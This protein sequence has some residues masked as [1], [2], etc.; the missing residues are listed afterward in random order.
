M[1]HKNT[2]G[3][4]MP[5]KTD[6]MDNLRFL[7]LLGDALTWVNASPSDTLLQMERLK[8][9]L[10]AIEQTGIEFAGELERETGNHCAIGDRRYSVLGIPINNMKQIGLFVSPIERGDALLPTPDLRHWRACG[11]NEFMQLQAHIIELLAIWILQLR[12]RCQDECSLTASL[13]PTQQ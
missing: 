8:E 3:F 7:M 11:D 10:E 13:W 4:T 9:G 6:K 12:A 2:K 1:L 5:Y